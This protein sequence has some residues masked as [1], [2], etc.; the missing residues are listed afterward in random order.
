MSDP[1]LSEDQ[2]ANLRLVYQQ[3]CNSYR[4]IDDFRTKLL[5]LLPLATGTG[6]FLLV[7]DE[8]TVDLLI[9][10][11]A[12][13]GAFGVAITLG[14]FCFELFGIKKCTQL[15]IDGSDIEKLISLDSKKNVA[16]KLGQ[17]DRRPDGIL[18]FIAEPF[19]S[20]VIYP[21]VVATW[22]Y[23]I[24]LDDP[25]PTCAKYWALGVFVLIFG[26]TNF[27]AYDLKKKLMGVKTKNS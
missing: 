2:Y 11:S 16:K 14:L 4:A 15:I 24:F 3:L 10:Y 8:D 7:G 13:V 22:T 21:A 17:F 12:P 27:Y 19:A 23:I 26:I 20:S 5:G 9:K 25:M 6:I 1:E 18:G